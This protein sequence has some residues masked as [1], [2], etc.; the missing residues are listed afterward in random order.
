MSQ[1]RLFDVLRAPVVSEKST[2]ANEKNVIVL[3]VAKDAT[4]DEIKAAVKA[5]FNIDALAVRTL[6]FQGKVRRTARGFGKRSDWKKAYITVP[7]NSLAEIE[8]AAQG[9]KE[10]N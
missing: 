2:A 3:K 1:A 7:E 5:V 4:K 10:S 8:Q 6:N 9:N